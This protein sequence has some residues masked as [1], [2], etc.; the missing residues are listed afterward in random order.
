ENQLLIKIYP[1]QVRD[2]YMGFV[3][4]APTPA[5]HFMGIFRDIRLKRSGSVFIEDVFVES[6]FD[7]CDT[8]NAERKAQVALRNAGDRPEQIT[9]AL[10]IAGQQLKKQIVLEPFAHRIVSF[11]HRDFPQLQ[12]KNPKLW[13]PNGLGAPSLYKAAV[14]LYNKNQELSDSNYLT[15]GIRKIETYRNSNQGRHYKINGRDIL[16]KAAGWV[17]DLFLR[18]LPDKDHAQIQYVH[19]MGLNALRLEG[20]WANNQHL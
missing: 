7:V 12:I 18:Y 6:D 1:P 13:W 3:D 11:D 20:V 9:L 17:D 2:F 15:F 16:I 10:R 14:K 5:D 8:S 19:D 4:W